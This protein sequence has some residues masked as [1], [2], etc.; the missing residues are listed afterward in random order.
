VQVVNPGDS[1][2]SLLSI[3]DVLTGHPAPYRTVS[4]VALVDTVILRLPAQAFQIVL[5][6][7]PESLVRVVQIIMIRLQRVTFMALHNYL[8]LGSEL[9]RSEVREEHELLVHSMF[10]TATSP[11]RKISASRGECRVAPAG[12]EN[13]AAVQLASQSSTTQHVDEDAV[14]DC[15]RFEQKKSVSRKNSDMRRNPSEMAEH[16]SDFAAV[17]SRARVGS[18]VD[19]NLP[20]IEPSPSQVA[21]D[22]TVVPASPVKRS[23]KVSRVTLTDNVSVIPIQPNPDRSNFVEHVDDDLAVLT[24]ATHDIATLLGLKDIDLLAGRCLL[25]TVRAGAMLVHEGDPETDLYFVVSGNLNILQQ[26]V[27]NE[28]EQLVMYVATSGEIIGALAVLTGEPSFMSVYA[29]TDVRYVRIRKNDFYMIMKAQ[30]TVVLGVSN[31]VVRRMSSFV[32]QID[33]ALD[34]MLID[35]GR[36]LY[37]QGER[38]DCVYIILTGRLRSVVQ[39]ESQK[40]ELVGEYGR[41]ELV[42]LVEVLTQT[43]R[44]TTMMAVR[45][46]ELAQIPDELLHTIKRKFPQVSSCLLNRFFF[47][48]MNL[49]SLIIKYIMQVN[50]CR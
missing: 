30:P 48:K 14:L 36:A 41:G 29:A 16:T 33:F 8:G 26:T 37:R 15:G 5:E 12:A 32:R 10:S 35:A 39:L 44:S 2:H 17:C 19:E 42:G 47:I 45:D 38:S 20:V 23:R 34:W 9:I 28:S 25:R 22:D 7:F 31:T 40:K 1:V 49:C 11:A 27:G 4:A 50:F 43:D 21:L 13:E 24:M 3:L 18:L 46:T 6:R